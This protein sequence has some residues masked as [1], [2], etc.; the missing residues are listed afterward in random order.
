MAETLTCRSFFDGTSLVGPTR[1]TIDGGVLTAVERHNGSCEHHLVT[2]GF[3][4]VQMNGWDDIDVAHATV[5]DLERLGSTLASLG[6]TAWLGTLVTAPFTEMNSSIAALEAALES[7]RVI[8]LVGAHLEGPFLGGSPGAHRRRHIVEPDL[9]W[10]DGLPAAVRLVTMAAEHDTTPE[11]IRALRARGVIVSLG[12][13]TPT[14]SQF[15]LAVEAGATMTTH[16]FNGMSGIHHR[17]GG[18]ALW[19][20]TTPDIV[21]GLIADMVHVGPDAVTLAFSVDSGTRICLVSDSVAWRSAWATSR[22]VEIIDGAPRLGDSTIAGSCTPLAECVRLAVTRS[23]VPVETALAAAT[24]VPAR[25][26]GDRDLGR[27]R[28][29]GPADLVALDDSLRVTTTRTRL[30]SARA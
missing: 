7:G 8:G 22:G 2:P 25:L 30:P 6:T 16:L 12:H 24:S 26:L 19:S 4:D 27:L 13:S 1:I 5:D 18:L 14:R 28:V 17:D 23:G 3:V 15:D 10:I 9:Q 11:A 20:L 29:G 21:C